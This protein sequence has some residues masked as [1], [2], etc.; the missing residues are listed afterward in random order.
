MP[1]ARKG[2]WGCDIHKIAQ[3]CGVHLVEPKDYR[4][5]A[6]RPPGMCASKGTLKE[7]GIAH[8]EAHLALVLRLFT[9]TGNG[10]ALFSDALKAV[11]AVVLSGRVDVD[12]ALFEAFDQVNLLELRKWATAL[13]SKEAPTIALMTSALL[14]RLAPPDKLFPRIDP[15]EAARKAERLAILRKSR[16]NSRKRRLAREAA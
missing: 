11:S 10:L 3:Q 4:A 13:R 16:A 7:I 8:G 9:E 12:G 1:R 14:W 6:H 5:D 15:E 2:Q